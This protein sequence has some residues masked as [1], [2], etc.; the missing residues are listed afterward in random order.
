[1]T[2]LETNLLEVLT[3]D[4]IRFCSRAVRLFPAPLAQMRTGLSSMVLQ[5][6]RSQ[7]RTGHM[8]K[9][10]INLLHIINFSI[11]DKKESNS[12]SSCKKY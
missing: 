4:A 3:R 11:Y 2:I 5:K 10:L 9:I 8:I 6:K 1:M 7:G 12:R